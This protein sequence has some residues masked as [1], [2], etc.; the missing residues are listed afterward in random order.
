MKRIPLITIIPTIKVQILGIV[1]CQKSLN[2]IY[3]THSP[4]GI[5]DEALGTKD[6]QCYFSNNDEDLTEVEDNKE[7]NED[8]GTSIL[9]SNI[10]LAS[11]LQ[12][13]RLE[14]NDEVNEEGRGKRILEKEE[15]KMF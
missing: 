9:P 8:Q 2:S 13:I 10:S 3:G 5:N 1:V 15:E 11:H 7:G 4:L 6:N 12:R 14:V